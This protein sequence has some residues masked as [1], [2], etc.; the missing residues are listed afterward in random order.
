MLRAERH[1]RKLKEKES[2][3][4]KSSDTLDK[5]TKAQRLHVVP[6]DEAATTERLK[7]TSLQFKALQVCCCYSMYPNVTSAAFG[8]GMGAFP[9]STCLTDPWI[10][11][12]AAS[13]AL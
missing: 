9:G 6:W 3:K 5:A 10:S 11:T 8:S 4:R 2:K 7:Y 12:V 13:S 1:N